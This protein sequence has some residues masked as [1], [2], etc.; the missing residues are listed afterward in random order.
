MGEGDLSAFSQV[1]VLYSL[2]RSFGC[3]PKINTRVIIMAYFLDAFPIL[4]KYAKEAWSVTRM[5]RIS[6][7]EAGRNREL[8]R[9]LMPVTVR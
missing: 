8:Y 2:Y 3:I 9:S 4:A 5:K 1:G 7:K 6:N